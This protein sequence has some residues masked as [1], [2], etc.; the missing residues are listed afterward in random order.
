[1]MSEVKS[2][3]VMEINVEWQNFICIM[4]PGKRNPYKVFRKWYDGGWHRQKVEEYANFIS[5]VE[6]VRAYAYEHEWGFQD[7]F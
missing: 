5:V 1:M 2:R 4:Y 7:V 6:W 3:K